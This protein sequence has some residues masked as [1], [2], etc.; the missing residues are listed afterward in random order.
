MTRETSR[1]PLPAMSPGTKRAITVHRFGTPGARPKAYFQAGIHADEIPGMLTLHHLTRL[2]DEADARGDI[3]GEIV[4]V[5]FANPIGL[6]Q[7]YEGDLLGRYE[8]RGGGNFNRNFPRLDEAMGDRVEGKLGADADANVALIRATF[9]AEVEALSPR[10]EIEAQRKT[11]MGLAGDADWVF[12]L[13]CDSEAVLH[14]F[15]GTHLWPEMADLSAQMGSQATMLE[16]DSGGGSFDEAFSRPWW[17]LAQRFCDQF[18]IPFACLSATVELRGTADVGNHLNA[19]DADNLLRYL[20]RRGVVAG[21]P[22][23][24]PEAL[25]DATPLAGIEYH[26]APH[27]GIVNYLVEPGAWVK[28]GD[29]VAEIIDPNADDPA[30]ART[31]LISTIDGVLVGRHLMKFCVPGE[32]VCRV[33]GAEPLANPED[34]SK[35]ED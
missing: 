30:T 31:P 21:D 8:F 3:I 20:Q 23:P 24:L 14:L 18:P 35:L 34:W 12:D 15:I 6:N 10:N 2:L 26:S 33:S 22:G 27:A 5:P 17:T 4:V 29:T 25:C 19:R 7:R 11:L 13:H 16:I 28:A 32:R 9:L 1:I